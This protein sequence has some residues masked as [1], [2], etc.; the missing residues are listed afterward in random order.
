VINKS[1]STVPDRSTYCYRILASNRQLSHP[2]HG[3]QQG[4]KSGC[5]SRHDVHSFNEGSHSWESFFQE[6]SSYL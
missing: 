5:H 6:P 3:C 2:W 4:Y 1:K